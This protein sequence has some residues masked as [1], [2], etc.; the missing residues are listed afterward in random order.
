MLATKPVT[1]VGH[2]YVIIS[3]VAFD[4]KDCNMMLSATC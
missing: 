2:H 4:R 1:T 3:T